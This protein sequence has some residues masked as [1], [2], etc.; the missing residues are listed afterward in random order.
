M[1]V[2]IAV[3]AAFTAFYVSDL[4]LHV[5]QGAETAA[6]VRIG[7]NLS[8]FLTYLG[9]PLSRSIGAAA[10]QAAGLAVL[11]VCIWCIFAVTRRGEAPRAERMAVAFILFSLGTAAMAAAGRV[12]VA[13]VRGVVVPVRYAVL[14][15]PMHVGIVTLLSRAVRVA[16]V[17]RLRLVEGTVL[18]I[19]VVLLL[20]QVVAGEAAARTVR[21]M[22]LKIDLF[23]QG[24]RRPDMTDTIFS[25]LDQADALLQAI[26]RAGL[27]QRH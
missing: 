1:V 5:A 4:A 27:Y 6:V 16:D 20:Q 11:G 22:R 3:G 12:E 8:Y 7:A 19:A 21:A 24:E 18:S 13:E 17:S 9:L 14:L 2:P 23:M 15:L 10:G 25:D 26:R